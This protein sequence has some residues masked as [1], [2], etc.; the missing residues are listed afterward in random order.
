MSRNK[1]PII[2]SGT[3]PFFVK[4]DETYMLFMRPSDSTYGGEEFQIAKGK[5]EEGE[6]PFDA[7][8]R[9][10]G[11]EL[12][13]TESNINWVKKAG[14]FLKTHH[15]FIVSVKSMESKFFSETTFETAE[16]KWMT[17]DEFMKTGRP[18]HKPIVKTCYNLFTSNS[19]EIDG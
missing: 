13:L 6:T 15:I 4:D 11:E 3:I 1:K 7:A 10:S 5:V 16:T 8:I 12:G 18:L 17:F 2:R 19:I 9:E 14:I